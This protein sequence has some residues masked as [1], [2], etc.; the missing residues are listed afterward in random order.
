MHIQPISLIFRVCVCVCLLAGENAGERAIERMRGRGRGRDCLCESV[1]SFKYLRTRTPAHPRARAHT[2]PLVSGSLS[3][4]YN[5]AIGAR[6]RKRGGWIGRRDQDCT[7]PLDRPGIP[8]PP[9]TLSLSVSVRACTRARRF[10]RTVPRM[11]PS[12]HTDTNMTTIQKIIS[13][14]PWKKSTRRVSRLGEAV[15]RKGQWG[16]WGGPAIARRHGLLEC[17]CRPW[18][19]PPYPSAI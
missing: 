13:P 7:P 4:I 2:H 3:T 17:E 12:S 6:G 11:F 8:L 14:L 19:H 5:S 16:R 10:V 15:G 18:H 1:Y 9:S